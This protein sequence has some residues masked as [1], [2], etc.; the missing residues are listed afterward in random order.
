MGL[1]AVAAH[2]WG[3]VIPVG[4]LFRTSVKIGRITAMAG[5]RH[6]SKSKPGTSRTDQL[7]VKQH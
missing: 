5:A 3:G 1:A 4:K 7:K 6:K 2:K